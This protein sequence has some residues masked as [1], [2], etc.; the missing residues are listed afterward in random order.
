MIS[1]M[2]RDVLIDTSAPQ[3]RAVSVSPA[4]RE[5]FCKEVIF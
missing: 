1:T 4:D 2:M 5:G 3:S